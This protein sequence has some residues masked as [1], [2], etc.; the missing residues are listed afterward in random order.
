MLLCSLS[1]VTVILL[2][3]YLRHLN[4]MK[5]L[6]RCSNYV[7]FESRIKMADVCRDRIGRGALFCRPPFHIS[8]QGQIETEGRVWVLPSFP[9]HRWHRRSCPH[10]SGVEA[11]SNPWP[12]MVRHA[13]N[14][15]RGMTD[16][17]SRD[18]RVRRW[19]PVDWPSL[20]TTHD[21]LKQ[22]SSSLKALHVMTCYNMLWCY[23]M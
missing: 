20:P 9:S 13:L 4:P 18:R 8:C 10:P 2:Y 14:T 16:G 17:P 21:T 6:D 5:V 1:H 7:C 22:T 15:W 23:D 19:L 11:C 3:D 12:L